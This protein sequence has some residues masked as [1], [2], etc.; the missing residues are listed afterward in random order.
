MEPPWKWVN[1]PPAA[2]ESPVTG[3]PAGPPS[4]PMAAHL[5]RI[6]PRTSCAPVAGD[7]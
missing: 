4:Q 6:A 2:W 5:V 7:Q 3:N 1:Q